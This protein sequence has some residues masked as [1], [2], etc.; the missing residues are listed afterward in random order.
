VLKVP[1]RAEQSAAGQAFL[2][3][4]KK[5]V[6]TVEQKALEKADWTDL[7]RAASRAVLLA[8][9]WAPHWAVE[10]A[11]LMVEEKADSMANLK[12]ENGLMQ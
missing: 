1:G 11:E 6:W 4:A 8:V 3:A 9:Y 7:K 12:A 2:S 10:R 5:V